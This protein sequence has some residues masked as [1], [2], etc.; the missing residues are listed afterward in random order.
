M[1][2]TSA[3][4]R[5]L[6]VGASRGRSRSGE[7]YPACLSY[8]RLARLPRRFIVE[9]LVSMAAG[10]V[11]ALMIFQGGKFIGPSETRALPIE[12]PLGAVGPLQIDP[13][14]SAVANGPV[15]PYMERLNTPDLVVTPDGWAAP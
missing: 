9:L 1:Y 4:A 7:S 6:P 14:D 12:V 3:L 5:R 15:T 11:V 8:G 2:A 10:A 13:R